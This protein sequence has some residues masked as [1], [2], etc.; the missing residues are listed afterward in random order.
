MSRR[1]F[2]ERSPKTFSRGPIFSNGGSPVEKS[3]F[4]RAFPVS[5]GSLRPAGKRPRGLTLVEILVSIA[6]IVALSGL[7]LPAVFE[8][9]LRGLNARAAATIAGVE[10]AL[11]LYES[12]F[13]DYPAQLEGPAGELVSLLAGFEEEALQSPLWR[14]PYLRFRERDIRDGQLVDPWGEPFHY[15]YPQDKKPGV[16]YLLYSTGVDRTPGTGRDIGNW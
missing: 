4:P 10:T 11:S 13:G 1:D 12:D 2:F 9:R 7:L 16:P 15:A 5:R 3:V 14:G 8:A 6:I